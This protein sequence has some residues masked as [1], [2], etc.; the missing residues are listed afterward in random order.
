MRRT[1]FAL[2]VAGVTLVSFSSSD[3]ADPRDV[4]TP[5]L[6]K[7]VQTEGR[8]RVIVQLRL[9]G[10]PHVPEG[11]L[12]SPAAAARQRA[13]IA[14]VQTRLMGRLAATSHR[15]FHRHR[16]VPQGCP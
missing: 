7:R 3:G 9:P 2:V 11:R 1:L 16:T 15:L 8:A 13:D 10:G 6:H 12:A 5:E 14:T 4:V